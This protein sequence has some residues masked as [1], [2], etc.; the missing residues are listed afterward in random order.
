MQINIKGELVS[1][2]EPKVMGILNIT[3]DSFYDG[4][5][6]QGEKQLL[7]QVEKMLSEGASFIDIGAYSSRPDANDVNA[8]EEEERLIPLLKKIRSAFPGVFLSIDT[9]R[10][11]VAEA[12][13]S[14]GAD[15]INDIS[16]G[17]LD[18]QMLSVVGKHGAPYIMMH[19]RGTPK[20]MQKMTDYKNLIV[21]IR[22]YFS[23]RLHLADQAGIKDVILDP[24]FGFA[25]TRT[26][27]FELMQNLNLF[28]VFEQ[29]ILVGI[30]R[31]SMVYK[32]LDN[33]PE[34]ALN[35]TTALHMYALM[36]KAQIL[37]VHDVKEAVETVELF[38]QLS[39]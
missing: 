36:Q 16:G 23:E 28:D 8:N 9:F 31:K 27:N 33:S 10:S 26:Q 34:E 2:E 29:P 38:N 35:G 11:E 5:F 14:E 3:P 24:G 1:L 21:D 20:T 39:I 12:A 25:K 30:S 7:Y 13:L 19:M 4:G 22:H 17:Q 15:I 18:D 37:R 32:T 6:H